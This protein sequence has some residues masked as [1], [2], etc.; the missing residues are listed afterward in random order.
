MEQKPSVGRVVHY[1]SH[2]SPVL[3]DGTQRYADRCRAA[4]ITDVSDHPDGEGYVSL[5]VLNPTGIF[6]DEECPHD[7]GKAPGS[8]H[9]PERT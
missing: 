1:R 6:F 5:C 9:W 2:G 7:E 3:P 4:I 8:W